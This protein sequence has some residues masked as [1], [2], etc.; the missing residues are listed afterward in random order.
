MRVPIVILSALTAGATLAAGWQQPVFRAGIPTV[1]VYATVVDPGGRLVRNLAID[2]FEVFD[3]GRRQ[4]LSLFA[5]DLRPITLVMMLDRSESMERHFTLVRDAAEQFVGHLLPDDKVRIGSFSDR[6]QLDPE[7][8]TSNKTT[9]TRI[10][11]H[12]LLPAG[13]TPLWNATSIAMTALAHEEGRRVVLVF[14]DGI[15]SPDT[16]TK[17]TSFRE[18]RS[19]AAAEGIMMYAIGLS[20]ICEPESVLSANRGLQG[21]QGIL[22]QRG[23][24]RRPGRGGPTRGLPI[25]RGLP[26]GM[27]PGRGGRDP[28][29]PRSGDTVI[30]RRPSGERNSPCDGARPD[31]DL[32][33]LADDS[34][35]GYFELRGT[36]D[37]GATFARV[38]D[39]LHH[40]YLLAFPAETLDG[41]VHALEVRVRQDDLAV[42]ARKSYV[43][44]PLK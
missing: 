18:V 10:L 13:L 24:V 36:D 37:L 29:G 40:Q 6:V 14:T 42:R 28:F 27:I 1:S 17:N 16:L 38:A 43:A 44:T 22:E 20:N 34:G 11:R 26:G 33:A 3:N 30:G 9:L 12:D 39:E 21:T 31:P 41:K 2:D 8:F 15:D 35:G 5:S 25:P 4:E 19:R 23:G 7:T 32:K